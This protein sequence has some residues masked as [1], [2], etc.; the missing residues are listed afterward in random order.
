MNNLQIQLL[1]NIFYYSAAHAGAPCDSEDLAHLMK[2][3]PLRAMQFGEELS[4][5]EDMGYL[6]SV[7]NSC[8]QNSWRVSREATISLQKNEAFDASQTK[9]ES[10]IDFLNKANGYINEGM[11][12]DQNN[13][14][15]SAILRLMHRNTHLPLVR[16]LLR[17]NAENNEMWFIL[18]MMTTL[19]AENDPYVSVHDLEQIMPARYVRVILR[20]IHQGTHMFAQKNMLSPIIKTEWLNLINGC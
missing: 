2:I 6:I 11:R 15:R 13:A 16:N 10:S 3:H 20:Q 18:V 9:I 1:T 17:L 12:F 19:V 7:I 4:K 8:G 14:I 5:L